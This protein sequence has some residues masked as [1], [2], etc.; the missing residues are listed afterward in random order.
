MTKNLENTKKY[1]NFRKFLGIPRD[2]CGDLCGGPM[3]SQ[4]CGLDNQVIR[5]FIRSDGS[6]LSNGAVWTRNV[7]LLKKTLPPKKMII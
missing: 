5:V 3:W 4:Q 1:E 6:I 2:L 7:T